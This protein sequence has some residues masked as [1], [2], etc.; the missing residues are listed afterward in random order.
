MRIWV[1]VALG[2]ALGG[3]AGLQLSDLVLSPPPE[4]APRVQARMSGGFITLSADGVTC[5][6]SYDAADPAPTTVTAFSCVD[7]RRGTAQVGRG[8][9]PL[10]GTGR[11]QL[12]DGTEVDFSFGSPTL[13]RATPARRGSVQTSPNFLPAR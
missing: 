12:D 2:A 6:G 11:L 3:C 1:V 5:G 9:S 4:S 8:T 10:D 13:A 7:G